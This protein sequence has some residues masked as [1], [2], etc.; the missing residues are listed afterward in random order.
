MCAPSLTTAWHI[1]SDRCLFSS[2]QVIYKKFNLPCP[3]VD[4]SLNATAGALNVNMSDPDIV[5]PACIPKMANLNTQVGLQC[6]SLCGRLQIHPH[7]LGH[8]T[9]THFCR[10]H[11]QHAASDTV[12]GPSMKITPQYDCDRREV[13]EFNRALWWRLAFD[14]WRWTVTP[15]LF[16]PAGKDYKFAPAFKVHE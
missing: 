4:F 8:L 13:P 15:E 9:D 11:L 14:I 1:Y 16:A 6:M 12:Y 3:F 10:S 2:V 7:C 5:D